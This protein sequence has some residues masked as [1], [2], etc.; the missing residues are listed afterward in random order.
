MV[1]RG[2]GVSSRVSRS[3]RREKSF[4]SHSFIWFTTMWMGRREEEGKKREEEGVKD[5]VNVIVKCCL[6]LLS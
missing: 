5:N 6:F 3:A 2:G 4:W 1:V